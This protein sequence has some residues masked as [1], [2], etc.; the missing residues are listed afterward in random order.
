MWTVW[1]VFQIAFVMDLVYLCSGSCHSFETNAVKA[2][3]FPPSLTIRT[4]DMVKNVLLKQVS[5]E[6]L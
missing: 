4:H 5:T 1:C 6:I 3:F 2:A